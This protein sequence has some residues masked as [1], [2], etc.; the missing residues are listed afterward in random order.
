MAAQD[1]DPEWHRHEMDGEWFGHRHDGGDEPHH[2]RHTPAEAEAHE[3]AVEDDGTCPV[4]GVV[5][6]L[7][8][9]EEEAEELGEEAAGKEEEPPEKAEEE[10]EEPEEKEPEK[11]EEKHEE[12]EE[13]KVPPQPAEE[14]AKRK[15]VV[16]TSWHRHRM[17]R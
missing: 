13:V 6:E 3:D 4:C 14:A 1:H 12:P 15:E 8:E 11:V 2:H 5:H 17:H 16:T 9:D 7:G 10:H